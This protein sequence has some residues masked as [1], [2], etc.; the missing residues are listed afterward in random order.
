V[1]LADFGASTRVTDFDKSQDIMQSQESVKGTP[2]FMAPEVLAAGKY[3]R[4]GDVWAVGCTMIQMLT[5]QPP[6][7]E[8][9]LKGL[10]Q[11]HVHLA[12]WEGGAPLPPLTRAQVVLIYFY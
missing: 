9:N 5:G 2:Y 6:W 8:L 11:L 10:V 7:K 1:K 4:K 3:G 12:C